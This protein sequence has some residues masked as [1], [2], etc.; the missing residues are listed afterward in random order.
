MSSEV[1]MELS[2]SWSFIALICFLAWLPL[3]PAWILIAAAFSSIS[4]VEPST[5]V[6]VNVGVGLSSSSFCCLIFS[7]SF[8]AWWPLKPAWIFVVALATSGSSRS[9]STTSG[10]VVV[11][12]DPLRLVAS[13]CT[14][15]SILMTSLFLRSFSGST[16]EVLLL[17]PST[18][19]VVGREDFDPLSSILEVFDS[20][21]SVSSSSSDSSVVVSHFFLSLL[22]SFLAFS[23]LVSQKS[24]SFFG[25]FFFSSLAFSLSLLASSSLSDSSS[26][27][28][29]VSDSD[30]DS[31]SD[32][33]VLVLVLLA[34]STCLLMGPPK[35]IFPMS[36]MALKWEIGGGFLIG[37]GFGGSAV[38]TTS[39][40]S[41]KASSLITS[42]PPSFS[43]G[44]FLFTIGVVVTF[45][46]GFP[47]LDPDP[48]D[49][50]ESLLIA[51]STIEGASS[52]VSSSSS[53]LWE[54]SSKSSAKSSVVS[55]PF[56]CS[57][58]L[59]SSW[60]TS[61]PIFTSFSKPFFTSTLC[62]VLRTDFPWK[63]WI[64]N[65]TF[66]VPK[67]KLVCVWV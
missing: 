6:R 2:S 48:P 21:S 59:M 22:S 32:L 53:V 55:L 34:G 49:P 28:D 66:L 62:L 50:D 38:A 29:S 14:S 3:K 44:V 61:V 17:W 56:A 58:A 30:S 40:A 63:Y 4:S 10:S 35:N 65:W 12:V 9:I 47:V 1:A 64:F 15:A 60:A 54:G 43:F 13:T 8:L 46:P 57:L 39:L 26:V 42:L 5:V 25:T 52:T 24:S 27:S 67:D 45:W 20:S 23:E 7:T 31:V 36:A 41:V 51:S 33:V 11:V 19:E 37:G 16:A 18:L